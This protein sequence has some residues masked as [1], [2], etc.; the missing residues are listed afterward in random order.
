MNSLIISEKKS[1]LVVF[2]S[3]EIRRK[4]PC[5]NPGSDLLYNISEYGLILINF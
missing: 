4:A 3:P 5:Q 1:P 2:A